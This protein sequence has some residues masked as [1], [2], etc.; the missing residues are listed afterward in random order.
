MSEPLLKDL[1]PGW[2]GTMKDGVNQFWFT[3][4]RCGPPYRITIYVTLDNPSPDGIWHW[5]HNSRHL[6][7]WEVPLTIT[8]SIHNHHH[9]NKKSCDWH[10][11]II[12]GVITTIGPTP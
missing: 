1:K 9:G 7:P 2:C 8:P 12:N 10:G 11:T 3:C 6:A 5:N 4:P